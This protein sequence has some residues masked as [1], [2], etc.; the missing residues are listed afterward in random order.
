MIPSRLRSLG[1][2]DYL[3]NLQESEAIEAISVPLLVHEIAGLL[4]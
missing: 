2:L 4:P 1:G 3:L